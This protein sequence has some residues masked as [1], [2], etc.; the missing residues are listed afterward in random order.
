MSHLSAISN[1]M[2]R[3]ISYDYYCRRR[4][5]KESSFYAPKLEGAHFLCHMDDVF[6]SRYIDTFF[7]Y[8]GKD[9]TLTAASVSYLR[10]LI[11]IK[12][13]VKNRS[14]IEEIL[15]GDFNNLV[16]RTDNLKTGILLSYL[17]FH[18]KKID[19]LV[20]P[21]AT[22]TKL[23]GVNEIVSDRAKADILIRY[24]A[25]FEKNC[26]IITAS[27]SSDA[28]PLIL[29]C[30]SSRCIAVIPYDS[31]LQLP[32]GISEL[33][34]RNLEGCIEKHNNDSFKKLFLSA[35][36]DNNIEIS[37][38]VYAYLINNIDSTDRLETIHRIARRTRRLPEIEREYG[39]SILRNACSDT[40]GHEGLIA[41]GGAAP[42]D[43]SEL[44][45]IVKFLVSLG[46]R[47]GYQPYSDLC[48][49]AI[50]LN[51]SKPLPIIF[52]AFIENG[53]TA[54]DEDIFSFLKEFISLA[55][56][57]DSVIALDDSTSPSYFQRLDNTRCE[58]FSAIA[59][60]IP[61]EVFETRDAAGDTLLIIAA[62][63]LEDLPHLFKMILDRTPNIDAINEDGRTALHY[64]SDFR[65]W[66]ALVKAGADISLKDK[67][68][69]IPS[70]EFSNKHLEDFFLS[71]DKDEEYASRML[72][73]VIDA[74]YSSS[75]IYENENTII[76]LIDSIRP[77]T[78]ESEY[79]YTP[80]MEILVQEGYFPEIYDRMLEKGID[81]NAENKA[82][83]SALDIVVLSPEC[84]EAKIRYLLE[85]GANGSHRGNHG[86]TATLAAGLFHIKSPEWNSL[87]QIQ[88][89]SI[90][91]YHT[92]SIMSPIMTALYYQNMDAVRFLFSHNAVDKDEKDEI[93]KM[94]ANIKAP[95]IR[96]EAYGLFCTCFSMC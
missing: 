16:I 18:E 46:L 80:L 83:Y 64:V 66:D 31:V 14:H 9:E 77:D 23:Y 59:P 86:T 32:S 2:N 7:M 20:S 81:I 84:T 78:R 76:E 38:F 24:L 68:G 91:T 48:R 15:K 5:E 35:V 65:R 88:D 79:G 33:E 34:I 52:K 44:I 87:W 75:L 82:G 90:F 56:C 57:N 22:D 43:S 4:A 36:D 41:T 93:R 61:S 71:P 26:S 60:Y 6:N 49:M 62:R 3:Q 25:A 94:I 92:A 70:P 10:Q 96:S 19:Y 51:D 54:P 74:S 72:F 8:S 40:S 17:L 67:E 21:Y 69:K 42:F 55:M 45:N 28:L 95:S 1:S 29:S 11:T 85:Y 63:S 13:K 58:Q 39:T 37:S 12:G 30:N 47:Y 27:E 89:K 73:S 53:Y 50:D